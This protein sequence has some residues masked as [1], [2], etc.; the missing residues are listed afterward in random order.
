MKI[1]SSLN[2][3]SHELES[4]HLFFLYDRCLPSTIHISPQN[5][6]L[7]RSVSG[8]LKIV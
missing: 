3:V 2:S 5:R 1:D 7:N 4:D 6:T 8:D